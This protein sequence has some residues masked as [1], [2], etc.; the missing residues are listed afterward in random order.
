[1]RARAQLVVVAHVAV[2]LIIGCRGPEAPARVDVER[3]ASVEV[4]AESDAEIP[5][6]S[7]PISNDPVIQAIVEIAN[8][9]SQ[10]A[11]LLEAVAV[12]IG[13]RLTG[14]PQL[15]EAELWAVDQFEA[16]GLTATHEQW[17]TYPVAFD[18]G[19]ASGAV[20]RP[21]RAPLEFGTF[22]WTPGTRGQDGL[23]AGGPVRGQALRYPIDAAQLRVRKPYL[24]DAWIMIPHDFERPRGK[25]GQQI[26]RAFEHAKIAG[27]V[28][29]AGD[30]EDR[31]IETH[32]DHRLDPAK[33]PTRV[34]IQLRGDQ[35]HAL[36]EQLD[37]GT[38]VELEFGVANRLLPGPVPV[39][40]VIAELAGAGSPDQR[41]IVGGHLDSWDGASGAVDNAAGVATTM[42]AARLIAAA[43][44]RTGQRPRRTISFQLWSG[45]EQGLLGSKAWVAAHADQLAGVSAALV[46]DNGTNYIS[47]LPV[48]PELH[49]V[50]QAVFEPVTKLAPQDMPFGLE[51]VEGLPFEPSDSTSF[52]REGVPAFFW[53]QTG[54]SDYDRYHH[55]QLDHADAVIDVYQRHSALVVA[56]AAWQLAQLPEPLDRHNLVSPPARKLGAMFDGVVVTGVAEGS[57]AAGAGLAVGDRIVEVAGEPVATVAELTAAVQRG[58]SR[59]TL[60][61]ERPGPGQATARVELVF[62]WT[63]D[64]DE[65]ERMARRAER[66]ER[67]GAQLRPW[68]TEPSATE[69]E[70]STPEHD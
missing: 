53:A 60:V 70:P 27:L 19:K 24:R 4:D 42:E 39:Y 57:L 8:D 17:G 28:Y 61:V 1:M 7:G 37:A 18:R 48:T 11:A 41:V 46:H 69:P 47:A 29:A 13:P 55:T 52:L 21:E 32:G 16:W 2:T 6:A 5:P 68:D 20:I 9:D 59:K 45:E 44:A 34:E 67:F 64:P 35:H 49:A 36:L 33:L 10:V 40:N 3:P 22:A 50:M 51:L 14:S 38:Y 23:E 58:E 43:C 30:R 62:D 66:R 25:L 65:T 56:I 26:E 12:E 54:R 15:L 31:R 63:K